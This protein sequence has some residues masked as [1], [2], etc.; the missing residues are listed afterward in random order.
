MAFFYSRHTTNTRSAAWS[1]FDAPELKPLLEFVQAGFEGIVSELLDDLNWIVDRKFRTGAELDTA[2][3]HFDPPSSW[4]V[5]YAETP[6]K[7]KVLPFLGRSRSMEFGV[8]G[9]AE[10][11]EIVQLLAAKP[12][13]REM[14]DV[15]L[16]ARAAFLALRASALDC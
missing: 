8:A 11:F 5:H 2:P 16:A 10:N 9:L 12:L 14:V 13:I 7:D 1:F 3:L 4:L 6:R 15:K